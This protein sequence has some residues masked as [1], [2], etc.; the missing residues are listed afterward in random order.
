VAVLVNGYS[1][2]AA[3]IVAACLQDHGRAKSKK[4]GNS[5]H[6]RNLGTMALRNHLTPQQR[7]S[8]N[9]PGLRSK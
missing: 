5:V 6:P 2:S 1:A 7:T 9:R 4:V 3:E 8:P